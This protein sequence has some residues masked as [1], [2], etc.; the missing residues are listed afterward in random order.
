MGRVPYVN[1]YPRETD[2]LQEVTVTVN[3]EP[4]T[5]DVEFSVTPWRDRPTTWAAPYVVDGKTGVRINAL[6]PG[7]YRVWARVTDF[8][9]IPVVDCGMF[10]IA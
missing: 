6:P 2:E 10:V 4:V 7:S 8:P 1:T 9:E 3:G 5:E